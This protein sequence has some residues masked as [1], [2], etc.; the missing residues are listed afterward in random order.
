MSEKIYLVGEVSE[1]SYE[2]SLEHIRNELTRHAA[3]NEIEIYIHSPGGDVYEGV[4]IYNELKKSGKKIKTYGQGLVGSIATLI[5]L[6]ADKGNRYMMPL[7]EFFIHNPW[8]FTVGDADELEKQSKDLK[9]I[10]DSI[11]QL[12]F[13]ETGG[14]LSIEEIKQLMKEQSFISADDAFKYGFASEL[15]NSQMLVESSIMM[16]ANKISKSQL[17]IKM[18]NLKTTVANML[19]IKNALA[20][21]T[22]EDGS[23]NIDGTIEVGEAVTV[24]EDPAP[25]GEH[26]FDGV[27]FR[28][29]AG[30]ITEIVEG[31]EEEETSEPLTAEDVQAMIDKSISSVSAQLT[32]MSEALMLVSKSVVGLR[33]EAPKHKPVQKDNRFS[34]EKSEDDK[35]NPSKL[36]EIRAKAKANKNK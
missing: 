6:A 13:K 26:T 22:N 30:I 27:T 16:N 17:D 14:I 28:T 12:Y 18:K 25:D 4:A 11:A 29:E 36:A 34:A 7:T 20:I 33:D 9:Q 24:D 10:E 23:Y 19:G 32:K 5:F 2:G 8:A 3:E 1:F 15:I 31:E 35:L 21:T